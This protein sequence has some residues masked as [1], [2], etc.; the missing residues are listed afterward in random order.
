[1]G[2]P[3]TDIETTAPGSVVVCEPSGTAGAVV[4]LTVAA[5]EVAKAPF[6]P[7]ASAETVAD[8]DDAGAALESVGNDVCDAD[9]Q[10]APR[11]VL[12][13]LVGT[14]HPLEKEVDDSPVG[15]AASSADAV[16]IADESFEETG[17]ANSGTVSTGGFSIVATG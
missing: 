10:N 4:A 14:P 11:H 9:A 5:A 12:L 16:P 2:K 13:L 1:M 7:T 17:A 8:G 3:D 15:G 6:V